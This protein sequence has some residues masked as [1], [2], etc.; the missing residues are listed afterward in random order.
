MNCI[1]CNKPA[2]RKAKEFDL[3]PNC[4]KEAQKIRDHLN[5]TRNNPQSNFN[6]LGQDPITLRE[7]IIQ[8]ITT[9]LNSEST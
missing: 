3:C 1:I 6:P 2:S 8:E 7:V 9:R 4:L 5:S